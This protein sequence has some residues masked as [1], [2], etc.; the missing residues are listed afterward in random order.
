MESCATCTKLKLVGSGCKPCETCV[1]KL[2]CSNCHGKQTP[3]NLLKFSRF[4]NEILCSLCFNHQCCFCGCF[5]EAEDPTD[6]EFCWVEG[7]LY[8]EEC[9]V[10]YICNQCGG[11]CDYPCPNCERAHDNECEC[12]IECTECGETF[13]YNGNDMWDRYH[14]K[15]WSDAAREICEDCWEEFMEE[16]DE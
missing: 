13:N 9:S 16:E 7:Y 12:E 11:A 14:N 3:F 1:P 6:E 2:K 8:C 5:S 10:S 4:D 15:K